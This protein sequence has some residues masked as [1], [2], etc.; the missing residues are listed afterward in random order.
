VPRFKAL[1]REWRKTPPLNRLLA[2]VL[3]LRG[4]DA[5]RADLA[6]FVRAMTGAAPPE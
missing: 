1:A 5:S 4:G 2:A 6:G 3:G